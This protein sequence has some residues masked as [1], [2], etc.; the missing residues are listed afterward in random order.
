MA[1][2]RKLKNLY[3]CDKLFMLLQNNWILKDVLYNTPFVM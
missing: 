2:I 3:F 1:G